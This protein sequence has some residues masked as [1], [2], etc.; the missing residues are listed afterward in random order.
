M[1]KN[2]NINNGKEDLLVSANHI[3]FYADVTVESCLQLNALLRELNADRKV[4]NIYLH[5]YSYGGD[6]MGAFAV[7]D[8][9]RRC[10]KQVISIV[11]GYAASAATLIS[12]A[13]HKR[14]ITEN[15]FMLIHE[16]RSG[17]EY[18]QHSKVE[19]RLQNDR[20]YMEKLIAHYEKYTII[21]RGQLEEML[22]KDVDLDARE[23][24]RWGLVDEIAGKIKK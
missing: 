20:K 16:M 18:L 10:S 1:K 22:K 19:E 21:P 12:S 24:V 13:C 17:R 7:V 5:I 15:S 23:C 9:I 8:T 14:R 6:L 11:E 3:Y 4:K 2:N